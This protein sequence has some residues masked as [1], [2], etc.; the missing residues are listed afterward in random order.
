[1]VQPFCTHF[2]PELY[3]IE[4]ML[5]NVNL[6]WFM[7]FSGLGQWTAVIRILTIGDFI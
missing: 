7:D 6:C 3:L 5:T 2:E 4:P 1:M